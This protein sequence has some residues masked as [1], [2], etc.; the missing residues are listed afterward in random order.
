[1]LIPLLLLLL[2]LLLLW[3][4][5]L[6]RCL[7]AVLMLLPL[8]LLLLLLLKRCLCDCAVTGMPLR[9]HPGATQ[10]MMQSR[11]RMMMTDMMSTHGM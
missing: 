9:Q 8:L 2:L 5:L 11:C 1:V 4:L 6:T 7:P 10:Q 3:L